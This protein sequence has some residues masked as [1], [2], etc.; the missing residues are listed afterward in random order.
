MEHVQAGPGSKVLEAAQLLSEV[1]GPWM[2][3]HALPAALAAGAD[4]AAVLDSV[5]AAMMVRHAP[6]LLEA[7]GLDP[8]R[9][10]ARVLG[11]VQPGLPAFSTSDGAAVGLNAHVAGRGHTQLHSFA[12]PSFAGQ[13]R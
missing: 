10:T 2:T 11:S 5:L 12:R 7:L 9:H 4:P 8:Q 6:F 3:H 1:L 13:A